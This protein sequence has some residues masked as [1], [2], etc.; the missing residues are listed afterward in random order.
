MHFSGFR[1]S[2]WLS[3]VCVANLKLNHALALLH[4]ITYAHVASF[5]PTVAMDATTAAIPAIGAMTD[6]VIAPIPYAP[7]GAAPLLF[8]FYSGPRKASIKSRMSPTFAWA[9]S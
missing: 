1:N 4:L 9:T 3:P 6:R 5:S 2:S 7:P 8:R